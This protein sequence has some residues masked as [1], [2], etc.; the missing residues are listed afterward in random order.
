MRHNRIFQCLVICAA[1]LLSA[2]SSIQLGYNYAPSLLQYQM[3]SYLDLDEEQE[4]LLAQELRSFQAWHRQDQLPVYAQTLRQWATKLDQPH[5]F[6]TQEVLEKQALFEQA[7]LTMAER[8]AYR[9]APLVLTLSDAQRAR[10]QAQF[11]ESNAEYAK[12]N[13]EDTT[14][15]EAERRERFE[16]RYQ[17]WLGDLTPEQIQTLNQWLEAEPS[18]AQLWGEERLARQRALLQL[19]ADARQLPSAEAAAVE[20]HNYFQSLS[21]YRVA[22]L[23]AERQAR[24][25][26]L[27]QLTVAL[28]NSMTDAQRKHLQDKLL[29]YA[30]DFEAL[31]K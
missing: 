19:L 9:L 13:L 6:T 4:A 10:L 16:Q 26:S 14:A 24:L 29:G 12:D 7:L 30:A 27:A 5:V 23:Q 3:D 21:R 31:S 18:R 15:S 25:Q 11:D 28:L 1:G 22:N 20:L 17:D 2:C 8:S